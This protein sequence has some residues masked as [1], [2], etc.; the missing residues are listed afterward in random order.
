[1]I[2]ANKTYGIDKSKNIYETIKNIEDRLTF[3]Y[4]MRIPHFVNASTNGNSV[5]HAGNIK[6][7]NSMSDIRQF[8]VLKG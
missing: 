6:Q 2:T 7:A 1:M 4:E 5:S 3:L 8:L